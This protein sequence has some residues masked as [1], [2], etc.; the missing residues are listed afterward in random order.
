MAYYGISDAIDEILEEMHFLRMAFQHDLINYSALARLIKPLVIE[1][2]GT[3]DVSLDAIIMGI[4]RNADRFSK[5]KVN[6]LKYISECQ[7]DIRSGMVWVN[8]KRTEEFFRKIV[9]LEKSIDYVAGEKMYIIQRTDEISVISMARFLPALKAL[10]KD[11]ESLIIDCRENLALATIQVPKGMVY[12]YGLLGFF[13]RQF[14][15]LGVSIFSVFSS[16][17]KLSFLFE[18]N[19]APSMYE[20]LNNAI[21]YAGDASKIL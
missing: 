9:E 4:R 18:E 3:D 14:E 21:K 16:F 10:A 5:E 17:T 20:R 7:V 19:D 1:R 15:Y 8:F 11:D 6:P 13:A 12:E 2:I